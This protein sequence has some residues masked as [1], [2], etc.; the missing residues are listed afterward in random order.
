MMMDALHGFVDR[1]LGVAKQP[2]RG[3]LIPLTRAAQAYRKG[4]RERKHE[5][6]TVTLPAKARMV[7]HDLR[8]AKTHGGPMTIN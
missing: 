2:Y 1:A 3:P 7:D 8:H 4:K 6:G 5:L